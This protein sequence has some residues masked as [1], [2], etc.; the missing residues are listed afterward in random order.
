MGGGGN[1]NDKIMCACLTTFHMLTEV[2]LRSYKTGSQHIF[3]PVITHTHIINKCVKISVL[4]M[5]KN[6]N[7]GNN[8]FDTKTNN[9][10]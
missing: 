9:G 5:V 7:P 6:Y 4:Y 3:L 2:S 1:I 8:I 10:V